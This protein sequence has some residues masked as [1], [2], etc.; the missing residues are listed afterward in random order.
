MGQE[1]TFVGI[2][3]AKA[4]VDVAVRPTGQR[5]KISY[6]EVGVRELVSQIE[7]VGPDLV[8][9]ESTGASSTSPGT[10]RAVKPDGR[11]W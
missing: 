10:G 8:L 3:V 9:L 6:D 1:P 2:D 5:W 4:Q 7:S 11:S